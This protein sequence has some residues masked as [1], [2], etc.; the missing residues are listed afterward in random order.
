MPDLTNTDHTDR[1]SEMRRPETKQPPQEELRGLADVLRDK[2]AEVEASV[3]NHSHINGAG[4]F[5]SNEDDLKPD[6]MVLD[7]RNS[8]P[9]QQ[10]AETERHDN[11]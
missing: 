1:D 4:Q 3:A 2:L 10:P 6:H 11:D 7:F 5:Q 9:R 8:H